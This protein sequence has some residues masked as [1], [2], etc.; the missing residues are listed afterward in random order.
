MSHMNTETRVVN[1][2]G[3]HCIPTQREVFVFIQRVPEN[4]TRAVSVFLGMMRE[5]SAECGPQDRAL[6]DA[7]KGRQESNIIHWALETVYK[8]K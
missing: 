4:P 3:V 8:E 2:V 7:F 5:C 1:Y 6:S